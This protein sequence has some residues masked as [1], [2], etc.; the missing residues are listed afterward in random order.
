MAS[1]TRSESFV[2]Q[3]IASQR[4]LY[5][6]I[7]TLLPDPNEASDVLQQTNMALWRDAERFIEGTSF[8][9][10]ALRIAYFMVLEHR[11]QRQRIQRR[12]SDVLLE[13]LAR[14]SASLTENED[15]RLIAMRKCLEELPASHKDIIR[16]RY[17][18]G[19]TVK[20]MA[21]SMRQT[22]NTMANSLYRARRMLWN[23]I[24]RRLEMENTR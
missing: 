3:V 12:F 13:N 14:E 22:A 15:S 7:I 19:E 2:E 23:C 10:W 1:L 20:A 16:R 8:I 4:R 17:V 24:N 18:Q 9:A 5:A 11:E 21:A 6:Y